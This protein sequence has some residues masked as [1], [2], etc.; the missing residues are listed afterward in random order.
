M[1]LATGSK[2]INRWSF[3]HSNS[4]VSFGLC[5][6]NLFKQNNSV[7]IKLIKSVGKFYF[8]FKIQLED[9]IEKRR[10]NRGYYIHGKMIS[11]GK[12]K[13]EITAEQTKKCVGSQNNEYFNF[14]CQKALNQGGGSCN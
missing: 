10:Q 13:S 7:M 4:Q 1:I 8:Y 12:F 6:P 5:G 2:L 14:I 11:Q 3:K 9:K